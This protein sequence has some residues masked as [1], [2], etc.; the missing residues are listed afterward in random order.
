MRESHKSPPRLSRA[1]R[2]EAILVL[3]VLLL[4]GC[5]TQSGVLTQSDGAAAPAAQGVALACLEGETQQRGE[6]CVRRI[7]DPLVQLSEPAI[8]VLPTDPKVIAVAA[9]AIGATGSPSAIAARLFVTRDGGATWA[10]S[11]VPLPPGA[12]FSDPAVAFG[13]DGALHVAGLA[14][15]FGFGPRVF[16]ASTTDDGKTWTGPT[17]L[18]TAGNWD[19]EWVSV[20]PEGRAFVSWQ[21]PGRTSIVAW[22]DDG[23]TWETAE[24]APDGCSTASP[25]AFV[26][27]EP[28]LACSNKGKNVSLFRVDVANK[29]LAWA[30]DAPLPCI[31]PRILVPPDGALLVTCYSPYFARST[32]EGRSWSVVDVAERASVEDAW[33]PVQSYWSEV[34]ARGVLHVQ[35]STFHRARNNA[36]PQDALAHVVGQPRRIGYVALDPATGAVLHE[37]ALAT[38]A[39]ESRAAPPVSLVPSLGDD[40]NGIAFAG[41]DGAMVWMNG[42]ELELARIVAAP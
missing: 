3:L 6:V 14:A 4:P 20:S 7:G 32:D 36:L 42:G 12:S 21:A 29:S 8:A 26:R 33:G 23:A 37:A 19:R 16:H 31:A 11:L 30:A 10:R 41:N 39:P 13:P 1:M 18:S 17:M 15:T 5:A 40:W 22:S 25:V 34:D 38:D 35:L 9:H 27:G 24:P 2:R 28:W